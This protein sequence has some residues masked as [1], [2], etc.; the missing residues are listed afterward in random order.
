MEELELGIFPSR[1]NIST[2]ANHLAAIKSLLYAFRKSLS[3]SASA[4]RGYNRL[5]ATLF[6]GYWRRL[7]SVRFF[8]ALMSAASS[9]VAQAACSSGAADFQS[10]ELSVV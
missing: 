1:T 9:T 5:R 3:D 2:A 7:I 10:L 4:S 8:K 6:K